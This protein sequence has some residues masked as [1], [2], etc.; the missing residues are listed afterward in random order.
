MKRTSLS[1]LLL[2]ALFTLLAPAVGFAQAEAAAEA[3]AAEPEALRPEILEAQKIVILNTVMDFSLASAF[4]SEVMDWERF[5]VVFSEE[6]ADLCFSLSAQ[7]D[8]QKEEIPTGQT[9]DVEGVRP[10]AI[11]TMR[12]LDTLYL[13]VFIPGGDDLWTDQ[14]D[15][16]DDSEAAKELVRRL[17]Q[18]IE[19]QEAAAA[20]S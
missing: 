1:A 7:A 12:T 18:R 20:E 14:E 10:R 2:L 3:T 17:R 11:G 15:V 5:E 16:G 13:K 19:D 9:S 8:Y 4:T 6:D